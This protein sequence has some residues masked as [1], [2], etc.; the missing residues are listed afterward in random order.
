MAV[1][2]LLHVG[3]Y[4]RAGETALNA[5]E[6]FMPHPGW[7]EQ[8]ELGAHLVSGRAGFGDGGILPLLRG[9][10]VAEKPEECARIKGAKA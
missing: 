6:Q 9:D 8:A 7:A 4:Q 2:P 1:E 10:H 5:C 3:Q